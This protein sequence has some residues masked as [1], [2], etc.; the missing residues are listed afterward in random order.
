MTEDEGLISVEFTILAMVH[1]IYYGDV[2]LGCTAGYLT[3]KTAYNYVLYLFV[4]SSAWN[5]VKFQAI[6]VTIA[7]HVISELKF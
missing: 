6:E 2:T 3:M 7:L 1:M 4:D 5:E